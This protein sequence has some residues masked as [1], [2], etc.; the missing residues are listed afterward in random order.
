M[1]DDD[2]DLDEPLETPIRKH[3][4]YVASVAS[5]KAIA[6]WKAKNVE[7]K[8]KKYKKSEPKLDRFKAD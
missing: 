8:K 4:G 6:E 7:L 1:S 3:P 2:I 5:S